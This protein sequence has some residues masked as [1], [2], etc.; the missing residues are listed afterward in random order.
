MQNKYSTMDKDALLDAIY[1][2]T[3]HGV[4]PGTKVIR[5]LCEALK[6]SP[7]PYLVVHVA[8]TNGK[9]SV[10]TML[11][12]ML[13][14]QGLRTGQ[15]ASPHL[16]RVNERFRVNGTIVGDAIMLDA[17]QSVL[18]AD[19]VCQEQ[20]QRP[21]TFFEITTAA[22]F[23]IFAREK[24]HIAVV[25]TGMG[26]TWDATNIVTPLV[27]VIT[28]IGFDHINFLGRTLKEIAKEKSGIIKKGRPAVLGA[29]PDEAEAVMEVQSNSC[30]AP[31]L[32]TRDHISIRLVSQSIEGLEMEVETQQLNVGTVRLPMGGIF[33][34]EN[35]AT[36]ILAFFTILDQL[37]MTI[38]PDIIK[39]GLGNVH[40]PARFQLL[41]RNP[42]IILDG[43]HNACGMTA[44]F[45][46]MEKIIHNDK[47]PVG[48]I[49]GMLEDKD[50]HALARIASD[51]ASRFW[52]VTPHSPRAFAADLLCQKLTTASA[53]QVHCCDDLPQA[54]NKA[55]SWARSCQGIVLVAGSLYL[56]GEVLSLIE[57]GVIHCED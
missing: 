13:R 31:L 26:G 16:V 32:Y 22:A 35:V 53:R 46:T 36:A 25:E 57:Q 41:S 48:M 3:S 37:G 14:A 47:T 21:A 43:A 50:T 8:G 42:V 15:Y 7:L 39:Q 2:R 54:W 20:G 5:T 10:C 24:V 45:Q 27:S 9:G 51:H 19:E 18:E 33:Q 56:A 44:L 11:E 49:I 28:R 1:R 34:I 52:A 6:L 30:R 12:G 17:I 4:R 29:M 38:D 40:W 55:V 23:L